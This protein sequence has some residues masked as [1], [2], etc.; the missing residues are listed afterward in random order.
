MGDRHGGRKISGERTFIPSSKPER[1]RYRFFT[2]FF[3]TASDFGG[4][5]LTTAVLSMGCEGTADFDLNLPHE[6]WPIDCSLLV[7]LHWLYD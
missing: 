2:A 6:G 3:H 5:K 7:I 1:N 4:W